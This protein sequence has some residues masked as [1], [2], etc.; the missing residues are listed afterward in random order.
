MTDF[1]D[2]CI[3]LGELYSNYGDDESFK[4]FLEFCDIG[5]PLAF[6]VSE[7][8]CEPTEDGVRYISDTWDL[9]LGA[10]ELPD[11]GYESL[12]QVLELAEARG[13]N[14]N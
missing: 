6:H 12:D 10:L 9:F 7:K 2:I 4:E 13:R 8:L 3:I 14:L 1:D 11:N 5:V